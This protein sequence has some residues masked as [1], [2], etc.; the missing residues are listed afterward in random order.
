MCITISP[1]Y[2]TRGPSITIYTKNGV[3]APHIHR[4]PFSYAFNSCN[5][6][7]H[8]RHQG[9]PHPSNILFLLSFFLSGLE[10]RSC[11]QWGRCTTFLVRSSFVLSRLTSSSIV[12]SRLTTFLLRQ[13]S[14]DVFSK[15]DDSTIVDIGLK[16]LYLLQRCSFL[17][18]ERKEPKERPSW[19]QYGQGID[20]RGT[21]FRGGPLPYYP[22]HIVN[23][24][25]YSLHMELN[26]FKWLRHIKVV[27]PYIGIIVALG[28][29]GLLRAPCG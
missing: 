10:E 1:K 2:T 3:G 7:Y 12:V 9:S 29:E 14:Y 16:A 18:Q 27:T 25:N 22:Q 21:P 17:S 6:I 23:K 5:L 13:S 15:L 28:K 4:E 11:T 19:L 24:M 26:N 20:G 8:P